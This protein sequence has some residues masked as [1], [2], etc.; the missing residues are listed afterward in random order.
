MAYIPH[1]L[2]HNSLIRLYIS[3]IVRTRDKI[4]IYRERER[5]ER[6]RERE[7]AINLVNSGKQSMMAHALGTCMNLDHL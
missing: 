2:L 4:Y 6:E 7:S 3:M 1:T 5:G